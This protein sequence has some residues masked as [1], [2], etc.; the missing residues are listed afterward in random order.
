MIANQSMLT[1][2]YPMIKI[3]FS[4][5]VC[6]VNTQALCLLKFGAER[7]DKGCLPYPYHLSW[8]LLR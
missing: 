4:I 1:G 6:L 2:R 3:V 8:G 7:K 5:H